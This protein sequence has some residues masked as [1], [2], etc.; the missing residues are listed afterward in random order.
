MANCTIYAV[1]PDGTVEPYVHVPGMPYRVYY[2]DLEIVG[3]EN[4]LVVETQPGT[5]FAEHETDDTRNCVWHPV[6]YRIA[7]R[8]VIAEDIAALKG[9]PGHRAPPGFGPFA[10]QI[11][12]PENNGFIVTVHWVEADPNGVCAFPYTTTI[13][14]RDEDGEE[15][16]FVSNVQAG[17]NLLGFVGDRMIVTNMGQSYSTGNFKH[18][19]GVVFAIRYKGA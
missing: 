17:Q 18:P 6:Q 2:A 10:G 16:V 14:R 13:M 3:E 11:F 5:G 15:H 7:G 9:G 1:D 12:R 19:D 8:E 4:V